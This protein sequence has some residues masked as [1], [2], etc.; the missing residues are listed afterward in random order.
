MPSQVCLILRQSDY[1][2]KFYG[3]F[4]ANVG[5]EEEKQED[6]KECGKKQKLGG[7]LPAC[8]SGISSIWYVVPSFASIFT[9]SLD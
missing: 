4:F 8:A 6:N 5:K 9:A 3:S 1:A 7:V 2:F